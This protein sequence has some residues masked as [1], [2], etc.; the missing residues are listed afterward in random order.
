[1]SHF[2][3][4][5]NG[6]VT[7]VIVA[8]Q[9]VIDSGIFGHGWVQTSYN[10]HGG[11]HANGNTP[12]RK[13]YAGVGYTYDSGRD[14]FIPP[15]PYPSW[16][17]SEETCLWSAPTPMP[18]D[19]KRYS[20]VLRIRLLKQCHE[21]DRRHRRQAKYARRDLCHEVRTNPEVV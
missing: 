13:N 4:V 19:D 20:W 2:A 11:V 12:L 17:L 8:E 7:Q 10:T 18:V 6:I 14:A 1:M 21:P 15:K 5:E 16:T 9:D 3:K